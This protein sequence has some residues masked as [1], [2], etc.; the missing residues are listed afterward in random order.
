M[1]ELVRSMD[2]SNTPLGPRADWPHDL[3]TAVILCLNSNFPISMAWGPEAVQIYNDGYRAMCRD[4]H[5]RALGRNFRECWASAWPVIGEAFESAAHGKPAFLNNQRMFVDRK[6]YLEETFFT[7]SFSPIPGDDGQVAGI[8]HPVT[9]LTEQTL[10]ERRLRALQDI[11]DPMSDAKTV[12]EAI[13]RAMQAIDQHPLDIPFALFYTPAREGTGATLRAS[14]GIQPGRTETGYDGDPSIW[15]L[16]EVMHDGRNREINDLGSRITLIREPYPEAICEAVIMPLTIRKDGA[17]PGVLVLGVSPRRRLD[18]AYRTFFAML[19]NAISSE[20]ANVKVYEQE[21]ERTQALAKLDQ[22]KTRFFS[23]VSH[24]LR[25]PLTL[26]LGPLREVINSPESTLTPLDRRRLETAERNGLRLLK[27]VNSLLEF[28]RV[29]AGKTQPVYA[30]VDLAR[31]TRELASMFQSAFESAGIAFEV[32]CPEGPEPVY[33]DVGMWENVVLNLLSNA[34]KYTFEGKVT[35]QMTWHTEEARLVVED[36]GTGIASE[37]LPRIFDRFHRVP[38]ARGRTFEGSGIGLALVRELVNLHGGRIDAESV[39]HQGSRFAVSLPLGTA[40][41]SPEEVVEQPAGVASGAGK[42]YVEEAMQWLRPG[43]LPGALAGPPDKEGRYRI[44]V[45]DDNADMRQYLYDLLS[46]HWQVTAV[47]DGMQAREAIEYQPP[48]L[49]ISDVMMPKLDGVE[50]LRQ[51]RTSAT[52]VDLPV[53]LLSA[54]AGEEARIEGLGAG[55]ND[56]LSKP[57]FGR[58]LIAR[59]EALLNMVRIREQAVEKARHD[60]L[61]DLPNRALVYEFTERLIAGADRAQSHIALLFIDMDN[62]K[63][64]NDGY[65]HAAGDAVLVEIADRLSSGI[66]D[67][68]TAG[69]IGG[70]EFVAVLSHIDGPADAARVAR[71]LGE[72][73][74]RP[75]RVAGLELN[76]T[77]SIGIALYPQDGLTPDELTSAADEAMYRAKR[78]GP[79]SIHFSG[80]QM[81]ESDERLHDIE[82]SLAEAVANGEFQLHYQPV[83]EYES[84]RVSGIEALLRWPGSGLGPEEFIPIAERCGVMDELGRWVI[85]EACRQ[86]RAWQAAGMPRLTLSINMSPGQFRQAWQIRHLMQSVVENGLEPALVQIEVHAA[87]LSGESGK[88]LLKLLSQ[89]KQMGFR[90]SLDGFGAD[91]SSL[92]DLIQLSPDTLKID[93]Q[94]SGDRAGRSEHLMVID[95]IASM[96]ASMGFRVVAGGVE[97]EDT[98]G[99]IRGTRCREVQ[100]FH[101]CPP[102]AANDFVTWY[103]DWQRA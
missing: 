71:H 50:L 83:V 8:F 23:N 44:L 19:W 3:R 47:A 79:G 73:L 56:F 32:E 101:I 36:T 22:E 21:W 58:E 48:H 54:K 96:G 66:R 34:L 80:Q 17:L 35:V 61:T 88:P 41:L 29:E 53:M 85:G 40:H 90:L 33:V 38:N 68:D 31:A 39:L 15:P 14:A 10:V 100:G 62:F 45:A 27:L 69:R 30:P 24:E 103:Q 42:A 64:I 55:A 77:P 25:T 37:D 12:D 70:D 72:T 5:P 91:S 1:G 82:R 60:P 49:L 93:H 67:E 26:L 6:G 46:P 57:F 65:G 4:K 51:L 89:V 92:G 59:V 86:L 9:E 102:V 76:T 11:T 13:D 20:L 43:G 97:D 99:S 74:S 18:T 63:P 95:G 87:H 16:D 94:L 28:S 7:A 84:G 75:Y 78:S 81:Q 98:L 52:T 2:W